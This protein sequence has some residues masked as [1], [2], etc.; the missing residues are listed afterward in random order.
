VF[1]KAMRAG[2]VGTAVNKRDIER[3]LPASDRYKTRAEPWEDIN[4]LLA[5][6]EVQHTD[7]IQHDEAGKWHLQ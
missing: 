1:P 4:Q 5:L 6:R 7:S 3:E 2:V